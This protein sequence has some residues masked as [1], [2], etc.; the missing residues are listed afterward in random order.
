MLLLLFHQVYDAA[1]RGLRPIEGPL[2][3][4]FP[5]PDPS[6]PFSLKPGSLEFHLS[7]SKAPVSAKTP[8]VSAA[9]AGARATATQ[10]SK[11]DE[12]S[13]SNSKHSKHAQRYTETSYGK[14][15]RRSQ[16]SEK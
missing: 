16:D 14:E 11:R 7:D 8:S 3:V 12:S 13:M 2:P 5:L 1:V 6:D 15:D 4:K 10:F 9:I